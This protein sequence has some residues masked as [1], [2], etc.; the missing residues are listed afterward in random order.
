MI[1]EENYLVYPGGER[2]EIGKS[3]QMNQVVDMNGHPL[4]ISPP[5]PRIIA[6]RIFRVSTRDETGFRRRY[7]YAELMNMEQLESYA[8]FG[9]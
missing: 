4:R 6:Y 3:L 9:Q 7:H 2:Q 5:A 8:R 1:L